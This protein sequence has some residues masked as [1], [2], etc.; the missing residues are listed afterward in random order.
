M[1]KSKFKDSMGRFLTQSLFL[2]LGYKTEFAV[3]TLEDDD[4]VHE[5]R[6]YP[7]LKKLYLECGDVTEY[8]FATL[9]L[10]GWRHWKRLLNNKLIFPHIEEW[11]EEL[12]L[13]LRADGLRSIIK[14]ATSSDNF[15]AGKYLA[16]K[17][18]IKNQVGRPSKKQINQMAKEEAKLGEEFEEDFKL[19]QLH[20]KEG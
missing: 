7:S 11:R 6:E 12:E 14:A 5:G 17:G 3:Y 15:S 16:E 2:E 18:W 13:S 9:Y 20:T 10:G 1:D 8:D 19:L 4:K